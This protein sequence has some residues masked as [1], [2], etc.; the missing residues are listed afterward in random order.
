VDEIGAVLRT[1]SG[2]DQDRAAKTDLD[3]AD[4]AEVGLEID[5]VVQK[6]GEAVRAIEGTADDG[7]T[8]ETEIAD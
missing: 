2:G 7:R 1:E 4:T 5:A 8:A 6:R 3:L